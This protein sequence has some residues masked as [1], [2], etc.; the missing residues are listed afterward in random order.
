MNMLIA[1]IILLLLGAILHSYCSLG[2]K[3][4]V[5]RPIIFDTSLGFVF[6][7]GWI[8]LFLAGIVLIF[9]ANWIWGIVAL[10]VY[11][12]ILP[13]IIFPILKRLV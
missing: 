6:Q 2:T 11:W 10:A 9:I 5:A 4:N 3:D 1:G 8:V 13:L 12:L 7:I